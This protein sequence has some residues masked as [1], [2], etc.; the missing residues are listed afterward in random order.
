[1]FLLFYL[2]NNNAG[3]IEKFRK[4]VIYLFNVGSIFR[5]LHY[6]DCD[7]TPK[8]TVAPPKI[9]SQ[10]FHFKMISKKRNTVIITQFEDKKF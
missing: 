6:G 2:L 7:T 5:F 4:F 10:S 3:E 9:F 1:M 8:N